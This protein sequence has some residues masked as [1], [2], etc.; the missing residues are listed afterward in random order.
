MAER[1]LL[2][3]V[4]TGFI[5]VA[6]CGG[7]KAGQAS[8]KHPETTSASSASGAG[9]GGAAATEGEGES[10]PG[11]V[12][13]TTTTTDLG[14]GGDLQGASI[15]TSSTQTVEGK[16]TAGKKPKKGSSEPGRGVR[17]IQARIVARRDEARAC[18]DKS[19]KDHPGIEGDLDIKFVI[20]PDGKV[21]NVERD[22]SKST[23]LE[24]DLLK[25]ISKII[26][27]MEFAP[28]PKGF[29]TR[30]HYPY[31]FHPKPHGKASS[32]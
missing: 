32:Q 22:D 10:G 27:S 18:Y 28:S 21:T 31:N 6:G 1:L 15:K 19:L 30:A 9:E 4:L 29:E 12:G 14:K 2:T 20:D 11:G 16:T 13:S 24:E 25:C 26:S 5:F 7:D 8:A 3:S 17:D 23:I